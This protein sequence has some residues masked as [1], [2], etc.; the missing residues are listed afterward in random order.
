M[1]ARRSAPAAPPAPPTPLTT[2]TPAI[3]PSAEPRDPLPGGR[4]LGAHL[5]LG[6]GMVRAAERAHAIGADS[7]QLFAD[8]P[9]AWRRR[10]ELPAEL[11]AFRARVAE[12]GRS[13]FTPPIS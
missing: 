5:A 8:N 13:P 4:R 6:P 10:A 7:L 1:P 11:P 9:T 3:T 2:A 12:L